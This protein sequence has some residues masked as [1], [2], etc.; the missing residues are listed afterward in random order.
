MLKPNQ[1]PE[2]CFGLDENYGLAV[3][4]RAQTSW[5]GSRNDTL[6]LFHLDP[7]GGGLRFFV[8]HAERC[9]K[10]IC[11]REKDVELRREEHEN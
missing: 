6:R 5:W 2:D 8:Y 4:E 3:V 10:L 7:L 9:G 1:S 11:R